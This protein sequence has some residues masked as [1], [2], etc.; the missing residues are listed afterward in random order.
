MTFNEQSYI[1]WKRHEYNI[2]NLGTIAVEV[3][4]HKGNP[5]HTGCVHGEADKL[6]LVEVLGQ[7]ASLDG[8][9]GTH[10]DEEPDKTEWYDNGGVG[11]AAY[12]PSPSADRMQ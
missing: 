12:Q 3:D 4:Q 10:C 7:V 2:A 6:G 5:D 11:L 9:D 8:V 1:Q